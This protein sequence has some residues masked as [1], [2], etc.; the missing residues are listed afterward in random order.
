LKLFD[1]EK[2]MRFFMT[3]IE[4]QEPVQHWYRDFCTGTLFFIAPKVMILDVVLII[5]WIGVGLYLDQTC[6]GGERTQTMEA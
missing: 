3:A 2:V 5:D 6:S 1:D 4:G